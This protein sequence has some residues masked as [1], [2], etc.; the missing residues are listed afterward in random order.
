VIDIVDPCI[1]WIEEENKE[2]EIKKKSKLKKK[3][4]NKG[5]ILKRLKLL[6]YLNS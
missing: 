2:Q 6:L 4:V 1:V 5:K 3:K